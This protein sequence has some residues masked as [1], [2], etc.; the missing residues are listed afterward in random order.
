MNQKQ[1]RPTHGFSI[2]LDFSSD[3][4]IEPIE[5]V[6]IL[7]GTFD[8]G[9]SEIDRYRID[10]GRLAS[11]SPQHPVTLPP[12]FMSKHLITQ[13]QWWAVIQ[14]Q[15]WIAK[16]LYESPARF[17]GSERPVE[18]VSWFEAVEFC[19]RL[20][21]LTGCTYRLPTE[22]EWEYAC[23]AGTTTLYSCGETITTNLAN[24][25][26]AGDRVMSWPGAYDQGAT[27]IFREETTPVDAFPPNAFGLYDMHGNVSE[28]CLDRWHRSY[29]DG[30]PVDGSAW[31]SDNDDDC[32]VLRG[33]SWI[34]DASDCRSAS[35]GYNDPTI[36][37]DQFGFRVVCEI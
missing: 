18:N 7:G 20:S 30:A 34:N 10:W 4:R 16:K 9:S 37:S 35:R 31:L 14:K 28:W 27:E 29:G 13:A 33:G 15:R 2:P 21:R 1:S 8:M 23:R 11:E 17:Q 36:R 26:G 3:V 19:Q 25:R 6:L 32:R 22:A 24:Y 12:F 5:M